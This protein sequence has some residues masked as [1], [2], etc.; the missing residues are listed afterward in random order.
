[1]G[2]RFVLYRLPEL[3]R[4]EIAERALAMRGKEEEVRAR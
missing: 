4:K 3:P 1:M 2:E